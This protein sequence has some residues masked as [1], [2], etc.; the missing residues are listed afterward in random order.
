MGSTVLIFWEKDFV[1]LENIINN[2][3]RFGDIVATIK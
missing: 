1:E 3:V 2:K